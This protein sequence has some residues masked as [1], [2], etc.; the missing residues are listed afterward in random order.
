MAIYGIPDLHE[1]EIHTARVV[2]NPGCF[3]SAAILALAPV[4]GRW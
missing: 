1:E 3:S 2:A 4:R